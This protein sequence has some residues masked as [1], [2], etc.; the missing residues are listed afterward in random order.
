MCSM[1]GK[2][3]LVALILGCFAREEPYVL[4]H[5]FAEIELNQL[6]SCEQYFQHFVQSLECNMNLVDL[7]GNNICFGFPDLDESFFTVHTTMADLCPEQCAEINASTPAEY[8]HPVLSL[9]PNSPESQESSL[10]DSADEAGRRRLGTIPTCNTGFTDKTGG[11]ANWWG[12]GAHCPGGRYW[13]DNSCNCACARPYK[14]LEDSN[15]CGPSHF[16]NEHN[17]KTQGRPREILHTQRSSLGSCLHRCDGDRKCQFARFTDTDPT[18]TP[19]CHLLGA[20][21]TENNYNRQGITE[22]WPWINPQQYSSCNR[23]DGEILYRPTSGRLFHDFTGVV[24]YMKSHECT[25]APECE[26]LQCNSGTGNYQV[27]H[28]RC[29]NKCGQCSGRC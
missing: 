4:C 18:T 11:E 27:R 5:P 6:D 22:N 19:T 12:C 2:F 8:E 9:V 23:Y 7:D 20:V 24:C 3:L 14:Q 16:T 25:D 21:L 13:T 29:P 15:L 1:M 28:H 17:A 26:W 10:V